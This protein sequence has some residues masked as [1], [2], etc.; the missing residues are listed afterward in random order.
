MYIR[1]DRD[2]NER[3]MSKKKTNIEIKKNYYLQ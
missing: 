3:E 2:E 1:T